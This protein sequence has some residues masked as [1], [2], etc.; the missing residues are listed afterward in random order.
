MKRIPALAG[1]AAA[2]L[3]LLSASALKE[4]E[5]IWIEGESAA[6]TTFNRHGWYSGSNVN[7]SALSGGDWLAH[8]DQ[9]ASAVAEWHF[10]IKE[11]GRYVWWVRLNPFQ[12]K[13]TYSL[14]GAPPQPLNAVDV[15][16][17][18]NLLSKGIDIRQIG[19]I[20]GATL[21][22]SPG[23]HTISI[24]V[25]KGQREAHGGIDCMVFVNFPW[26]PAGIEKPPVAAPGAAAPDT[27]FPIYADDDAFS[28]KSI[29][30]MRSLIGRT[31]GIPA[32]KFGFV[33]R[34][35]KSFVFSNRPDAPVK[36]WGTSADPAVTPQ[37]QEQ[38]ARF[39]VKHGINI[40]R[41]HTVQAEIGLLRKDPA[42]GR[43]SFDP[44]RLDRFDRW[45]SIL[46]ANGIYMDWSCFY[47]HVIT[48]D[49]GY[50]ADLYAELENAEGGK[51]TS[52][53]V[54]F[55]PQLQEA[56]W[57]WEKTLLEH[58][59][60]YTGLRYVEDPALAIIEVHNEDCIFFHS[61]LNTLAGNKL[62]RHTAIL[63]KGWADWLKSR[64]RDDAGLKKVW[65]TGMKPGDSI[66]NPDMDIYGAWQFN[67]QGPD[68]GRTRGV[69][70]SERR[71]MGDFIR[72]LA[73]T[74][75]G[76]YGRRER[77]LRDLG[78]KGST[79][80]TA[81]QSGGPAADLA[82]LWCDDAMDAIDRHNYF[83]GGA[84][85]HGIAAG[86]VNN[87]THLS[88]PGSGILASGFY[89]V[90]DKPFIMTEWT[91]LP[92]TQWKAE[93]AP[94]FAFY[95]MGLQG[96]DA[97]FHFAG[98]RPRMGSGWPNMSS[99][100]TETPHYLG[101]F[102]A[103]AFAIYHNHIKEAPQA[104]ARRLAV[105][106]I[107]MGYDTLSQ[108]FTGGGYDAKAIKGNPDT[109]EDVLAI[110]RIT[111]KA[112]DGQ[113]RS[114]KADWDKYRNRPAKVVKSMTGQLA[115]DYGKRVVT[116]QGEKT[117]AVVG[118]AGG[119][120]YDLPGVNVK[121]KTSF[122]SIILTPLDDKPLDKSAHILITAMAQDKQTGARYSGDGTELLD[123]GAPPLLMEPVQ[124]SITFKGPP[125]A[126]AK[127]VDIYGVPT[128]VDVE[129]TGNTVTIDGRYSTYYYEVQ[130]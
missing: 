64:Y 69:V 65:G 126:S 13:H 23:N 2:G 16:E 41:K 44:Q 10:S 72:Y 86:K 67:A 45:F 51:S 29:I 43:R 33:Q 104:A 26:A 21:D 78:Y 35:G 5:A 28:E 27:W 62:P 109:P 102:P 95:G 80:T 60:P 107:F 71:R 112:T 85:G 128:P 111:V 105:D 36:F 49:D 90:E 38:Q 47:P 116:V 94:L 101:Q 114:A 3:L 70:Q 82:N 122:V 52:G 93:I 18:A 106:D 61:P 14:D 40:L 66:T 124:A 58:R 46:K 39:Y 54:N 11:G 56:E 17:E 97:S 53:M 123:V 48:P 20:K 99:Y 117:Q 75:R 113:E 50:P 76:Y 120:S 25:E 88:R 55:M 6:S 92:P 83:G 34:K 19:W 24:T 84:G 115:W 121:V 118:F 32:G 77:Q 4:R 91:V 127:A 73:E 63:K 15:R 130:R 129:R 8:Y 37:L 74:Q 125:I 7:K 81:W 68:Y 57:A 30:D 59:N 108:D 119:G 42:T 31:T 12:I 100:V 22:L 89:Q 87:E 103:L 98:S 79:V 9:I 1:L 96:W 110:G